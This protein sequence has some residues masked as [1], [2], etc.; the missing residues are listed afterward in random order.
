MLSRICG[1]HQVPCFRRCGG[2]LVLQVGALLGAAHDEL[3]R[4]AAIPHE[5]S[6][7]LVL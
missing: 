1:Q 7:I 4:C 6:E 2:E 5:G 3:D